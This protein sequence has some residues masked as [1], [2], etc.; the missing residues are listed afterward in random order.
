ML[1]AAS[2]TNIHVLACACTMNPCDSLL[3][4]L[5]GE[6]VVGACGYMSV[7]SC[8][9]VCLCVRVVYSLGLYTPCWVCVCVYVGAPHTTQRP[10]L[11]AESYWGHLT[12]FLPWHLTLKLCH[13]DASRDLANPSH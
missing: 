13:V 2:Q 11:E 5:G 1:L 8:M 3:G 4:I 6:G 9:C 7:C 10:Y 12:V